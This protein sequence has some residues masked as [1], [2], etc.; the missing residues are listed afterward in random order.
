M[1]NPWMSMWLSAANR[2]GGTAR[3]AWIA[4]AHRQQQ[5]FAKEMAKA[6]MAPATRK[7]AVAKK[8]K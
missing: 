5:S 7:K 8:R 6:W 3:S 1:K 4:E 2:A